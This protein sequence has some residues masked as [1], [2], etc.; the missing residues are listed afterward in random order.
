MGD[1]AFFSR[2]LGGGE[3]VVLLVIYESYVT[4]SVL[5]CKSYCSEEEVFREDSMSSDS[6]SVV[7]VVTKEEGPLD[8]LD[9]SEDFRILVTDGFL[10][11][12]LHT[13]AGLS[14]PGV[15]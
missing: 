10:F 15:S 3:D 14:L 13:D 5:C 9:T 2:E 11:S 12:S 7:V 6:F 8:S 1:G 4:V